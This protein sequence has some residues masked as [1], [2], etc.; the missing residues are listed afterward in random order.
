VTSPASRLPTRRLPNRSLPNRSLPNRVPVPKRLLV[1]GG[2]TGGHIFPAVA[3]AKAFLAAFPEGEVLFVG[4]KGGMETR[5]VPAAGVPLKTLWISGLYRQKTLKNL[6]RNLQLPAKLLVSAV[7]ARRLLKQYKPDWVV[8][9]GGYAAFPLLRAAI[10][11]RGVL[12]AVQE[13]NAF[14]GLV[15]RQ[16]GQ[17]VDAI[18]LG[19]AAA[20]SYFPAARTFATGNPIR[21]EVVEA[22]NRYT[23]QE[24]KAQLGFSPDKPLVFVTG[25]SLGARTL[26][27]AVSAHLI[28]LTE[29][30]VQVLWQ[31][32]RLYEQ[33]LQEAHPTLPHT[34]QLKAFQ[35]HMGLA[36]AAADW[37]VCRAGAITLSELKA[38][39][40]PAILVPSPNVAGDHQTQNAKSLVGL[41]A[42]VLLPDDE[43]VKSLGPRLTALVL[44]E[45]PHK[46]VTQALQALPREGG[47]QAILDALSAAWV[48]HHA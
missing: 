10:S 47:A 32:G 40:Q 35:D 13:Q 1:T 31:C 33:A 28:T 18:L 2:G 20:S 4:A 16:L 7:Q 39:N 15:N 30:G 44:N 5:M 46:Q 43:A 23:P 29:A 12:T 21:S 37:V 45:A 48:H 17:Q 8:G 11:Q 22:A 42:G 14:P 41:G 24:A 6:W 26:N 3:I 38:L 19:N 36:Y 34:V 25:G 27:Q 9:T